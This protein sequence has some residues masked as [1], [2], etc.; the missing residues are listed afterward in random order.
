MLNEKIKN[1]KNGI[2]LY[3]LTPPKITNS[4]EKIKQIAKRQMSYLV[5]KNIDGIV[6]YDIQDEQDRIKE[7][8]PFPFIKT[9]EPSLY[10]QKYWQEFDKNCVLYQVVGNH[11]KDEFEKWLKKI[12]DKNNMIFVGK[13]S[14]T[15]KDF[16]G[17]REAYEIKKNASNSSLLGA[18]AIPERHFLKKDEHIKILEKTK[19]GCDFFITQAIYDLSHAKNFLND[20]AQICQN[21]QIQ[22][23]CIILTLTPC[24]NEKTLEFIKW[25]GISIPKDTEIKLKNSS[26]MLESSLEQCIEN[27]TNLYEFAKT[28]NIPIG[29][30]IESVSIRKEEIQAALKLV[31][32]IYELMKK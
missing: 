27:F 32:I 13:S 10:W 20:Y 2:L 15:T 30:N 5:D 8:R 3:G 26:N 4:D 29:A 28:L 21:E 31:D 11:T 19:F 7:K 14:K 1:R 16:L 24:G 12:D 17:V 18:I 22:P 23:S 9:I 25:L 6:L